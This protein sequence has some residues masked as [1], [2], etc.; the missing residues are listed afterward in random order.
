MTH[1]RDCRKTKYPLLAEYR[2]KYTKLI[3]HL[4]ELLATGVQGLID[5]EG[6]SQYLLTWFDKHDKHSAIDYGKFLRGN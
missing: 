5:I 3:E 4:S 6:I 2:G 1:H